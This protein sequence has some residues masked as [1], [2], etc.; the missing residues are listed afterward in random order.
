[1]IFTTHKTDEKTL[2]RNRE[3]YYKH[4]EEINKRHR[5]YYVENKEQ[6]ETYRKIYNEKNKD[7]IKIK[8]SI[9]TKE[10]RAK[11]NEL[12]RNKYQNEERYRTYELVRGGIRKSIRR[13]SRVGFWE[14]IVGYTLSD[15]IVWLEAQFDKN[16]NW[17]NYGKY[18]CIDHIRP[19][20]SF[21]FSTFDDIGLYECYKLENLRPLKILDNN[22]KYTKWP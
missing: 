2:Q 12:R 5:A 4:K 9:Y 3:Y 19:V 7:I 16:M 18:W 10:N 20:S 8:K 6:F 13:R 14:K 11:W 17:D 15:L 21:E 1:M 22:R